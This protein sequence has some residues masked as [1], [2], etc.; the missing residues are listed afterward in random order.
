MILFVKNGHLGHF[1]ARKCGLKVPGLVFFGSRFLKQSLQ[2]S[3][4][5]V[6][7]VSMHFSPKY[8]VTDVFSFSKWPFGPFSGPK[9]GVL[10]PKTRLKVLGWVGFG[11]MF[12]QSTLG[13]QYNPLIYM[14]AKLGAFLSV[15]FAKNDLFGPKSGP[16]PG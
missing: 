5:S 10:G 7:S 16:T 13:V 14:L 3:V 12:L 6:K 4:R 1:R 9:C 15:F 8:E 2:M 11:S